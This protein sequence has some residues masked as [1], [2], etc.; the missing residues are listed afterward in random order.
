MSVV[1][2][3]GQISCVG[4]V[5]GRCENNRKCTNA[6]YNPRTR[7]CQ[8]YSSCETT[9]CMRVSVNWCTMF[10]YVFFSSVAWKFGYFLSWKYTYVCVCTCCSFPP[11]HS[12]PGS[13]KRPDC[14]TSSNPLALRAAAYR[15]CAH[16]CIAVCVG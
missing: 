16:V 3:T 2:L 15:R 14:S 4:V 7:I 10:Y 5:V 13:R 12:V 6:L 9:R 1:I 11:V 8:L